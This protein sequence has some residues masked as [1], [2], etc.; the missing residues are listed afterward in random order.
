VSLG[1]NA[2]AAYLAFDGC[3]ASPLQGTGPGSGDFAKPA[4]GQVAA[5]VVVEAT[6]VGAGGGVVLSLTLVTVSACRPV[7][8]AGRTQ[9]A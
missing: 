6:A 9:A 5:V 8:L 4:G 2:Q 3:A 7:A 1:S